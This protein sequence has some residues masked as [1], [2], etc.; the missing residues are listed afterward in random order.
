VAVAL[1]VN[2]GVRVAVL[3]GVRVAVG[4]VRVRCGVKVAVACVMVGVKLGVKL[5]VAVKVAQL[6]PAIHAAWNTVSQ[7]VGHLPSVGNWQAGP[8]H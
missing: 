3:T 6:A 2:T 1:A 5:G 8:L 4:G 7:S